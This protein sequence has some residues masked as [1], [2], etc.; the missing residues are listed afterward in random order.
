MAGSGRI[1][2][3]VIGAGGIARNAHL[4][5]LGCIEGIDLVAICDI[6]EER[7]REAAKTWG[8]Q[9]VHTLYQKMLEEVEMDAVFVLL[10]PDSL[11]RVSQNCI[12]AGKHVFM[13]KPPGVTSFETATLLRLARE[14]DRVVQV[15][16]NRRH[17]PVVQRAVEIM[18]EHTPITQVE[19]RFNK[20]G[21]AAF[22]QGALSAF[23]SDTIHA[24]DLVRWVAGGE[25][26]A[27]A[28]VEGQTDDIVPNRWNAVVRFDNGVTG[29][30][31]A[32]YMTGTRVHSL[33]IH[34]PGASAFVNMGFG[35]S[36]CSADILFHAGGG[37]YSLASTG[38][39][40]MERTHLE[41]KE[42]AGRDEFFAYYGFLQEDQ[43]FF[44]CIREGK[45]SLTDIEEGYKSVRFM[46]QM[47]EGRL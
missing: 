44:E 34:G 31:R 45:R 13:E 4:P 11:F 26:E 36:S 42:V 18:R 24:A 27:C 20:H 29:M 47:L 17:I 8:F 32:N 33:E 40:G 1:R 39:A 2:V 10:E 3:G 5:S 23:V 43:H 15:G 22:C 37:G 6:V 28:T 25:V 21:Q 30:V 9:S 35:D 41:G 7:A 38:T 46:E 16:F 19:G 14:H 12:S